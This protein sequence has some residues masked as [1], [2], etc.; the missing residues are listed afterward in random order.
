MKTDYYELLGVDKKSTDK[1]IKAA[2]RKAALQ[3][4]PDRNQ[5]NPEAEAK[6]KEVSEAYEVLSD[7]KKRSIYD[8]FGHQ[9]LSGQGYQGPQDM[10]DIFSSFGN[11]FEDFFG[12]KNPSSGKDRKHRGSDLRYDLEIPFK[13]A[14]FGSDQT[15]QYD[16]L[17][18]CSPCNGQGADPALGYTSCETCG[19]QGQVRR[20]QGFFSMATTCHKC[21]GEG[22]IPKK[23]CPQCRGA[24]Q[25]SEKK[26]VSLKIPAGVQHGTKLRVAGEGEGGMRGGNYGDLYVVLHVAQDKTFHRDGNNLYMSQ[27]MSFIQAALGANVTVE[28]MDGPKEIS[29]PSGSQHGD[30]IGIPGLGV[31]HLKKTTRGDLFV[32]LK[33]VIPKKISKEERDLL[34]KYAEISGEK[35][36]KSSNASGGG[37]FQRIF[38]S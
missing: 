19:G 5:G 26:K 17:I 13:D 12:F 33:L 35:G 31:P 34:E 24:G 36:Y 18:S 6:F 11:I 1:D 16:R 7:S 2:Y 32:E 15:V 37:F 21:Q 23:I 25:I 9:G 10:N 20:S 38:D 8:Q 14:V 27:P 22:R 3:Y 30:R 29:I 28:T 4:H